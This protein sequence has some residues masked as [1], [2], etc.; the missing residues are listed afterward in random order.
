MRQASPAVVLSLLL[1][2]ARASA[3]A[4]AGDPVLEPI[5]DG[6]GGLT[7]RVTTSVPEAQRYFDQGLAFMY[8]FNHDEAIRSFQRAAELDPK[9]AMAEWGVAI[10]NGPHINNPVLPEDR[11]KAA[12]EALVKAQALAEG[13]APVEKALIV[14][15]AAR[16]A[17]PQPQDRKP[18]DL[19]YANAM[20]S[21][22]AAFPRDPDVGALFAEAMADL[23][24]WDFWTPDGR[25]QPGTEEMIG[26]LEAVLRLDPR[27]P[28]ALH[29]TI[30]AL[31]ASTTPGSA[32][33]A[34]DA[35]RD[36]QPG[37]GHM[38]H[39]PS[40]IDVRRGRWQEAIAANTKAIAA[41]ARY[42]AR[43]PEQGFYR[44]Y[45]AHNHHMLTYAAMMT[46]QSALALATIR[47]MVGAIPLEFFRANPFAD[48]FMA[49]P[50]EVLM[51]FG[52][53][54]EILAEPPFPE[55]VPISSA[56]QH[57]ARGVALVA[58]G[59]SAEAEQELTAFVAARPKVPKEAFFGNNGA[60][61]VLG[62][63]EGVLR[64]ELLFR[65]GKTEE[66]IAALREAVAREDRL[67]YDE[68]P[69]WIQPVRHPLGAALLQAGRFAEAEVVF[70]QD[71]ERLPDNGWGLYGLYRA[72]Q[73]QKKSAEAAA[74]LKRFETVWKQADIQ[75]QSPCL[76]LPGV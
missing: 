60:D 44:L 55:F 22:W 26:A 12:W 1:V 72:L 48:G 37:L 34:A 47:E 24:P 30:H 43:S 35:L 29:L 65:T 31:E 9:C 69:D 56:L 67:R 33:A 15:L 46:G 41:D 57:Y 53:W 19:A 51:R 63:A 28:L 76:C 8:G 74:T 32:D 68:P 39:M 5:F 6:L 45:M 42:T 64:G 4:P 2:T 18:L 36:R 11:A 10:A 16:Y 52:R 27:H 71:L 23:R 25:P 58:T 66:G 49:M 20:R 61:D 40:H 75:I 7:R 62:V 38:V 13:A 17:Q 21:V 59:R 50:L 70:R 14:A 73:L 54:Q 3:A